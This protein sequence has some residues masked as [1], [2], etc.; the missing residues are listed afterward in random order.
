MGRTNATEQA[1]NVDTGSMTRVAVE[2][3]RE[4]NGVDQ[5]QATGDEDAPAAGL[6][7]VDEQSADSFPASDPPSWGAL[8]V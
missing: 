2:R 6:D 4:L 1:A 5:G 8:R 3:S 7:M